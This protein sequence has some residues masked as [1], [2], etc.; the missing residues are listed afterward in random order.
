MVDSMPSLMDPVYRAVESGDLDSFAQLLCDD[1]F[2]FTPEA[3]GVLLS[4]EQALTFAAERFELVG[5]FRDGVR[6]EAE[7][8]TSGKD[9][10]EKAAW[11]FDLVSIWVGRPEAVLPVR[12]RVTA[13]LTR[14]ADVWRVAACYWSLP[15][16]TQA[17][18]DALKHAGQLVPG[19]PLAEPGAAA[20]PFEAALVE[21]LEE[22]HLLPGL[23]S[24]RPDHATI[25]SVVDEVFLGAAGRTAWQ[26]FVGFVSSF[27]LRGP[28]R[29]A[30]VTDDAGWLAANI[31]IGQPPTHYR[32]FYVWLREAADWRI[33]ISHDGVER[34]LDAASF[35]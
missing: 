23:Y 18:Q 7:T 2:V 19:I 27:A 25:G 24:A 20:P 11:V 29:G 30:L 31:D 9:P 21:A 33:V 28:L 22:P 17:E 13:L 26:E 16:D 8:V 3:E 34:S 10:G 1:V 4:R 15:F 5:A 35:R 32:F 12:V 14:E 6:L